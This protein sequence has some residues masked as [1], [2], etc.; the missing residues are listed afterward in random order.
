MATLFGRL[1]SR[2]SCFNGC[3]GCER[4]PTIALAI[5]PDLKEVRTVAIVQSSYVPWKGYFDL[6]RLAD[7]FVIYDEVQYTRSD[8]R[9]RNRIKTAQGTVWLTIPVLHA[10]RRWQRIDE[11][12]VVDSRWRRKHWRTLVQSYGK[13]PFFRD[14]ADMLERRYL[15]DDAV[16]LTTINESFIRDVCGALG[17]ETPISRSTDFRGS[18]D[19]MSRLI[20]ICAALGAD[21]YLTGP[22]ARSYLDERR[23][24][25]AGVTVEYMQYDRYPEYLQLHQPF[26]HEVSVLDLLF[27]AGPD[28]WRYLAAPLGEVVQAA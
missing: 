4:Y 20:D 8:W 12:V 3:D 13:A 18:G 9:N 15:G 7:H 28:A 27:A 21:R 11:A 5:P 19:R 24:A 2:R 6:I 14:Y 10:G 16:R 17:I 22:R 23:F 25:V 1:S 26:E